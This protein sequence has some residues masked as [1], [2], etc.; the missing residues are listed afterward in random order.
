V[1]QGHIKPFRWARP[2]RIGLSQYM[3]AYD[4]GCGPCRAFKRAISFVDRSRKI[5]FISLR[6]A[7]ESGA[8]DAL[9]PESRY[10]TFRLITPD[11][12]LQGGGEALPS[13]IEAIV[14]LGP[15]LSATIESP[16]AKRFWGL[17]YSALS[18]LHRSSSCAA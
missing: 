17:V 12:R 14:P 3:L 6:D 15:A 4:A 18:K 1:R 2:N 7:D 13:L 5:G 9:A 11:R 10:L 8:L 16:G